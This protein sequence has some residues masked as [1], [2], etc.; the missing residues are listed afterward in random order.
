MPPGAVYLTAIPDV[1]AVNGTGYTDVIMQRPWVQR[2]PRLLAE[3]FAAFPNGAAELVCIKLR[4][5]APC[6]EVVGC[7]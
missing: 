7:W 6:S 2:Q 3:M 4:L 5:D 1:T